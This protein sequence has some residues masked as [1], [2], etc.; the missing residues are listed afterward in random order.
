MLAGA[1]EVPGFSHPQSDEKVI[2]KSAGASRLNE[3]VR[4]GAA[5]VI[6]EILVRVGD[7]VKKGQ[8]LGHTELAPTKY[9]LDLARQALEDNT[10]L[11]A[12]EGQAEASE[13]VRAE[14]EDAVRRRK[15]EKP[16]L[17]W[18][19]G[20]EQFHHG[21]H[22]AQL[23]K[24][25]IQRI[26]YEYWKQQY[27]NR[28]FRAPADGVVTEIVHDIGKSIQV[29]AHVFTVSNSRT[30]LVPL[31]VPAGLAD[32]VTPG[33]SL[34]I[35]PSDGRHVSRGL[36]DSIVEDPQAPDSKII[37]LL[38]NE[39]D[40]PSATATRMEGSTFDVLLP[41]MEKDGGASPNSSL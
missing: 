35:R 18:A 33:S 9:Q 8:L 23:E 32:G 7:E 40:F 29:A 13:A 39:K 26:Q 4:A 24:K 16:R 14:T 31:S 12:A 38:V 41:Q 36:V 21:N 37:T 5:G 17:D 3:K 20:M 15:V 22:K 30:Y 11:N 27:D 6:V 2:I 28:F 1:A 10:S 34:L 25:K 19:I